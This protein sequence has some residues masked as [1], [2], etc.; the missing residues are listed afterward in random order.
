VVEGALGVTPAELDRRFRAWLAPRLARFAKQY[1][2]DLHVRPLE[3][4]RRAAHANPRN[5][6]RLV[7]LALALYS[8]GEK[9][10]GD[11]ALAE[12]L[13]LDPKQPDAHYVLLRRAMREKN[14]TEAE[15]LVAKMIADGNDGYAVRMKAAD[16]AEYKKDV[17]TEKRHLEAAHQLDP[18]QVEPLQALYDLAH[19]SHDAEGE[20]WALRRIAPLDQHDRKAWNLLLERL[21]E[22]GEWEEARKIGEGAMFVDVLNG[23]THRLYSR[24]LARTGHFADAAYELDSALVCHPA[25]K[26]RAEILG[27]LADLY[28]RLSEPQKAREARERQRNPN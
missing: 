11:A 21:V 4:A 22:R 19:R 25:P 12:A 27:E 18:S 20:L 2:P 26:D 6:R 8:H 15:R 24:A 23:K 10:Q 7:D 28:E 16:I 13:R 3:E 9:P 5:A 17:A 1:L 14:V